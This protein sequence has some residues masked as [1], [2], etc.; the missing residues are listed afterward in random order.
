MLKFHSGIQEDKVDRVT[1]L[2]TIQRVYEFL[3]KV[4]IPQ[5]WEQ[6]YS[7]AAIEARKKQ[8]KRKK[9]ETPL[10][11][12]YGHLVGEDTPQI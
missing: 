1:S 2:E 10:P 6:L 11:Y 8:E 5:L 4:N 9:G 3:L 12:R 7:E